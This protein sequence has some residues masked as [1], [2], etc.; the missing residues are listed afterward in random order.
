LYSS[1]TGITPWL[2]LSSHE[3]GHL[4]H[5]DD[6]SHSDAGKFAYMSSFAAEYIGKFFETGSLSEAHDQAPREDEANR[7]SD[8]FDVFSSFVDRTSNRSNSI[9]HLFNDH[10]NG[11]IS[12]QD[13]LDT[14]DRWW[15]SY[16]ESIKPPP[17][18]E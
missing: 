15:N 6:F 8:T 10:G 1:N 2:R 13:A 7:G 11:K 3:V 4:K 16:Q 18:E 12:E 14:I 17:A 5:A 9:W